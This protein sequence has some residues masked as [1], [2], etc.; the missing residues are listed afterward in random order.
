MSSVKPHGGLLRFSLAFQAFFL[1]GGVQ[2]GYFS[3]GA[4][5]SESLSSPHSPQD[6][7]DLSWISFAHGPPHLPLHMSMLT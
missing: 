6:V 2:R 1:F 4:S 3:F 5:H 7:F